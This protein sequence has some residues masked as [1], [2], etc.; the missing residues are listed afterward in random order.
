[1]SEPTKAITLGVAFVAVLAVTPLGTAALDRVVYPRD[2]AGFVAYVDEYVPSWWS[3]ELKGVP[4]RDHAWLE[5]HPE[6]VLAEGD[7]ACAWLA[8]Q[9]VVPELVPSG[10][11]SSGVMS[12]RYRE[13]TVNV[14]S[15]EVH[16]WT[17][18]GVVAGAW[19]YLCEATHET[20]TSP[21]SDDPD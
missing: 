15:L 9:P 5:S 13:A 11:A 12:V 21:E 14:T 1:M 3:S 7:A 10:G 16:E 4:A 2:E 19:A 17:R 20:R 6:A 18:S 8:D